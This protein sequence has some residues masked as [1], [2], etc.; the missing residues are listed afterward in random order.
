MSE[1]CVDQRLFD[2][3]VRLGEQSVNNANKHMR[4]SR[5]AVDAITDALELIKTG[6]IDHA[7]T[8]LE[9]TLW[10]ITRLSKP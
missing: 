3:A 8:R 4:I 6:R 2:E 1:P 9:K 7:R 10:V 5:T